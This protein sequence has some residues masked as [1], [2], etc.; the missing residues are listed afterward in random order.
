MYQNFDQIDPPN[1]RELPADPNPHALLDFERWFAD[2][3]AEYLRFQAAI[4]RRYTKIQWITTNYMSMFSAVDPVRSASDLDAFTWTHYPVH[5][6]ENE[7]PLGFR[8]GNPHEQGFMHSFMRSMTGLSGLMELQPGQVNWGQINPWPLPGAIRMWIWKAFGA[9]ANLVCTYRYRQPLYGSELYHKGIVETDGVSLSPGGAEYSQAAREIADLRSKRTASAAMPLD[10]AA[11]RTAVL[12]DYESRWD[13]DNHRQTTLWHTTGHWFRYVRALNSMMAPVEVGTRRHN[14]G[15]YPFLIVPAMQLMD[16]SFVAR[17]REYVQSGGNLV[18]T[19]RTAQKDRRGQL[20]EGPWAKP[21]LDLIG[22][23]IS[24]YDVLL[25]NVRGHVRI[26]GSEMNYGWNAWA[27]SLVPRSGTSVLAKHVDQLFAEKAAA[28]T[29][30][31]GR[32]SVTYIGV[33]T[34][35]GEFE[36]MLLQRVYA[37]AV[38]KTANLAPGFT[39]DWRDGFFVATNFSSTP[40]KIPASSSA[41][42]LVGIRDVVPGGVAVWV[43]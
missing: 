40:Q 19:A 22:A 25:P 34:I 32:G 39:V 10:L 14:F 13:I 18:L 42:L 3:A 1:A 23:S 29:R 30:N 35:D 15:Q 8:L 12:V 41:R 27:E 21:I 5:G 20:W 24:Q 6:N 11:R 17:L 31:L 26:A 28:V 2:E 43:E 9:G 38:V 16:E 4:L 36:R 33:D 37:S 7:G